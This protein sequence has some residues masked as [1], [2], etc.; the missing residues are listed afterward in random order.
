MGSAGRSI[1]AGYDKGRAKRGAMG[2]VGVEFLPNGQSRIMRELQS[3]ISSM[4]MEI[5]RMN[6]T[7]SPLGGSLRSS[8]W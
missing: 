1:V 5:Y 3:G 7:A 2:V 4:K 6:I 8:T